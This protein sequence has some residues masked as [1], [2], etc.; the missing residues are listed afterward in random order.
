MNRVLAS[1]MFAA[2]FRAASMHRPG[3]A[4]SGLPCL[5]LGAAPARKRGGHGDVGGLVPA[6]AWAD[7]VMPILKPLHP[8]FVI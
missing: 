2:A 8:L 7:S 5:L 6:G 1:A 3:R 4:Q